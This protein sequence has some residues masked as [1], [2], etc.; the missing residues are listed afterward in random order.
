MGVI[1][2]QSFW[3]M[4]VTYAGFVLGAVNTLF[5]YTHFFST[6]N[7]GLVMSLVSVSA[8]VMPFIAV[9]MNNALVRFLPREADKDRLLSFTLLVPT[10]IFLVLGAVVYGKGEVLAE[11]FPQGELIRDFVSLAFWIA[12]FSAF[13]EVFFGYA[14]AHM[15]STEG[16]FLREMFYRIATTVL[17]FAVHFGWIGEIQF[18]YWITASFALRML[19]M[20]WVAYR[21]EEIPEDHFLRFVL[22]DGDGDM[23]GFAGVRQVH[24]AVLREPDDRGIL[25]HCGVHRHDG[26]GP[27]PFVVPDSQSGIGQGDRRKG[28]GA[29]GRLVLQVVD[30]FAHPLRGAVPADQ[31]QHSR[32]LPFVA[33]GVRGGGERGVDHQPGQAVRFDLGFGGVFYRL[34][35]VFS[36]GLGLFLLPDGFGDRFQPLFYP[37]L[38]NEWGRGVDLDLVVGGQ[39]A[40]GGVRLS[41]NGAFPF[42]VELPCAGRC[43]GG[44]LRGVFLV[45][46]LLRAR[47]GGY[48]RGDRGQVFADRVVV[49]GGGTQGRVFSRIGF[50]GAFG[51]REGFPG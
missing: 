51:A 30:E 18:C 44:L 26:G 12:V 31:L 47:G 20:A 16:V 19:L 29:S 3:N 11:F 43:A 37:S 27:L 2:R 25:Y 10:V 8:I 28:Y 14:Q 33:L 7:Y 13:F 38:G 36:L 6:E 17:L 4:V 39:F 50:A 48:G 49:R 15:R 46:F 34:L 35:P 24:P 5:L 42:S 45:G 41:E 32:Y 9:G 22:V 23:G 40:A 1:I 21:G